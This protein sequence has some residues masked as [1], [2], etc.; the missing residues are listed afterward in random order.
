MKLKEVLTHPI[1]GL[2]ALVGLVG[3]FGFAWFDP[4]WGLLSA[5]AGTWFPLVAVS[6]S[7]ILPE[8]GFG[9]YGTPILLGAAILFVAIQADRLV[10]KTFQYFNDR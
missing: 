10:E 4:V 9:G 7:T 6:T 3:Q 2:A 1:S 5:T 8:I